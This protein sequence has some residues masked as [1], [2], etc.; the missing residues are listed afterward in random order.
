M[1]P[2]RLVRAL[3]S[4]HA[5]SSLRRRPLSRRA[6]RAHARASE[7]GADDVP[8]ARVLTA[9]VRVLELGAHEPDARGERERGL[10]VGRRAEEAEVCAGP[11]LRVRERVLAG[12]QRQKRGFARL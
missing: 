2:K 7:A 12:E 11:A 8:H 4:L 5:S 9:R 6:R 10:H 3:A 1:R